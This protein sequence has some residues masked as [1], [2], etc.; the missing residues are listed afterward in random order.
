[1]SI[2]LKELDRD[3]WEECT[4]LEILEEQNEY[5]P[6]NLYSIAQ[7]KFMNNMYVWAIYKDD[8]MVGFTSCILDDDGDMNVARLMIDKKYQG[9]GYGK[10]ALTEVMTWIKRNFDNEQVWVSI[11]PKNSIGIKLYVGLGFSLIETGFES[12]DEIFLKMDIE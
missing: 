10:L 9:K 3:N 1:M 6:S 2:Q 7:S 4:K 8:Y 5:M 11:H 12:E